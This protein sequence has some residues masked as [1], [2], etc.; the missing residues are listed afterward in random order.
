V[1]V[2]TVS[3]TGNRILAINDV[4][5]DK[6]DDLITSNTD[7]SILTVYYF[8]PELENYSQ[9]SQITL[10]ANNYARNVYINRNN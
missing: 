8:D 1:N 6:Y 5:N 4:N 7:G 9:T 3:A 2:P 10:P